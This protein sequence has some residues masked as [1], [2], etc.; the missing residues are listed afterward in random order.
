MRVTFS[1]IRELSARIWIEVSF[2]PFFYL[3]VKRSAQPSQRL[4]TSYN[5][6]TQALSIVMAD[7]SA[8]FNDALSKVQQAIDADKAK[9]F[10]KALGL[11]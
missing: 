8:V 6:F 5:F 3:I 11:Y 7:T 1:T 2:Q 9:D 4:Y 10:P